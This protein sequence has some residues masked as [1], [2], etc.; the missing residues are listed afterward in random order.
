MCP[1]SLKFTWVQIDHYRLQSQGRYLTQTQN[2]SKQ[3]SASWVGEDISFPRP[4]GHHDR[5]EYIYCMIMVIVSTSWRINLPKSGHSVSTSLSRLMCLLRAFQRPITVVTGVNAPSQNILFTF[6]RNI[7]AQA[8]SIARPST[9][10]TE[11]YGVFENA[12][13]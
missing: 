11:V 4:C 7:C 12:T 9:V 5:R 1:V 8:V 6:T 3:T 13:M 2:K 10:V